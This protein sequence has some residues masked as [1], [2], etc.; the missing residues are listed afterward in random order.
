VSC[1]LKRLSLGC[2]FHK[3]TCRTHRIFT[4]T[5]RNRRGWR[6]SKPHLYSSPKAFTDRGRAPNLTPVSAVELRSFK[7]IVDPFCGTGI[8]LQA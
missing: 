2:G 1:L 4:P 7:G 8:V 6:A 3:E 5:M